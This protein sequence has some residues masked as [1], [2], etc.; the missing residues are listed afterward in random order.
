MNKTDDIEWEISRAL[1]GGRMTLA[2][3]EAAHLGWLDD[4]RWL[5]VAVHRMLGDGRIRAV[6]CGQ[7]CQHDGACVVE[8]VR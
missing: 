1:A 2:D 8:M 5:G 6:N 3:L 7:G 4:R